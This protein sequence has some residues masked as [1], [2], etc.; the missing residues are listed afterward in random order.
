[1]D[2]NIIIPTKNEQ[3]QLLQQCIDSINLFGKTSKYKYEIS[4]CCKDKVEGENVVWYPE[5][6]QSGPL[7]A[8]NYL[9]R[10]TTG[11]YCICL[12]EDHHAVSPWEN[13]I[14]FLENEYQM[15]KYKICSLSTGSG[16]ACGLPRRGTR[17]GSILN[18][19]EDLPDCQICR[20]PVVERETIYKYMNGYIFHPEFRYH[21]GDIY[22]GYYLY[23]MGEQS[24]ECYSARI[25][26]TQFTKNAEWECSDCNIAYALIKNFQYGCQD[27]VN[28]PDSNLSKS[29]YSF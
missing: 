8:F 10:N 26:Q 25:Q 17:F 4:I 15:N 29:R 13:A 5:K 22:L 9:F 18:L 23:M 24:R 27:Y 11:K 12:V 28:E 20:F 6:D 21:A 3:P 19:Q 2:V 14:D 16:F 1:M 7:Y